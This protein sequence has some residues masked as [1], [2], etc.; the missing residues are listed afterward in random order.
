MARLDEGTVGY[1]VREIRDEARHQLRG[2]PREAKRQ[3]RGF[4]GEAAQQLGHGWGTE[5][6]RQIFGP[7]KGRRG[8]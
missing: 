6:A 8:R 2:F 3:L 1:I 4:G 7:P 5:I